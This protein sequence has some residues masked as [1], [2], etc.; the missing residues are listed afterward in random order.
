[1]KLRHPFRKWLGWDPTH[2]RW[3]NYKTLNKLISVAEFVDV[4]YSSTYIVPYKI[5]LR[6]IPWID[7]KKD[8]F[9]FRMDKNLQRFKI[10]NKI[11]WN[12][13]VV[14]QKKIK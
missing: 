5:L 1:M 7:S 13:L 10:F 9:L 12:I 14:C 2:V 4:R 11:G 8:N 6:F 3:Y